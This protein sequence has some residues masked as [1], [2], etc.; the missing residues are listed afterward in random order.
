MYQHFRHA[1][2]GVLF[3]IISP[4]PLWSQFNSFKWQ[5]D[6]SLNAA[7]EEQKVKGV[8]VVLDPVS[9]T[10]I[11]NDIQR[12]KRRY[13]PASTFKIPNTIIGLATK[14]VKDVDEV[15]PYGGKPQFIKEWEQDMSLREA[16][17]VSNVPVYQELARRIGFERMREYISRF[18]YG[19][20]N[21]GEVIDRFWLDGP[22]KISA[23]EQTL[24]LQRYL[25]GGF[26][27]THATISVLNSITQLESHSEKSLTLH[28]KTGWCVAE[29]PAIGWWVGWIK[30]SSSE[31]A[32]CY[33]AL[34]ID[35][36]DSNDAPKRIIIGKELLKKLGYW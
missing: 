26:P 17:R 34:N 29:K 23:F 32:E 8:F 18:N 2:F 20:A 4:T 9:G 27:H 7:F 3:F 28:G 21:I 11:T 31:L 30:P 36:P 16:I 35:M 13:P 24:F 12:A 10:I 15:L 22:L 14:T 1:I 5:Q 25:S 6:L 33:F 19:N